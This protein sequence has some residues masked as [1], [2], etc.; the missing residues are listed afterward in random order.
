MPTCVIHTDGGARG[1]PGPA[2]AGVVIAAADASGRG[3]TVVYEAGF[4]LGETTNNVAE[5]T[6]LIR[7]LEQAKA[8][9]FDA[10]VIR[11]DS[12]LMV[13]QLLGEYRV[14]AA[15][16][17]PLY[18]QA[19]D[20]LAGFASWSAEHVYRDKNTRADTLANRAMDAG[21]D[22]ALDASAQPRS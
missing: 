1:N 21:R 17:K 6:G 11:S 4:Y 15:N 20:A 8:L 7:G 18:S 10:V 12:Q 9:G 14:K 16:L 19:I 5:Y 22:V 13:K 3:A 2:G